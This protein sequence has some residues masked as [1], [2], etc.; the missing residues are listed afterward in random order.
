MTDCKEWRQC[1]AY[2]T[3]LFRREYSRLT[4]ED[5]ESPD[6][7]NSNSLVDIIVNMGLDPDFM[8]RHLIQI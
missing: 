8:V 7:D 2:H 5:G 3:E 1:I 4:N 6:A